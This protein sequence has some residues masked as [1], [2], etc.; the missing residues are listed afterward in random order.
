M[1]T[2]I[3]K[4]EKDFLENEKF[5]LQVKMSFHGHDPQHTK[6]YMKTFV[7]LNNLLERAIVKD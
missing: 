7:I 1:T 6:Y 4:E 5:H 3:T 2:E